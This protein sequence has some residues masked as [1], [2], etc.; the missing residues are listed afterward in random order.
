VGK[1]VSFE[2]RPIEKKRP[3]VRGE[4]QIIL[5]TG[6]RYERA[7]SEPGKPPASAG[8]KRKRG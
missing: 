7:G 6:I 5:F 2:K 4:A 3:Q 8:S 1:L